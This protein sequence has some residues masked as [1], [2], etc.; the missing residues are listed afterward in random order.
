MVG[1]HGQG[2]DL[3]TVLLLR[4]ADDADNEVVDS[5]GGAQEEAAVDGAHGDLD[6]G[7]RRDES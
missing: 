5:A 2:V 6:H 7:A 4:T 1:E 3:H